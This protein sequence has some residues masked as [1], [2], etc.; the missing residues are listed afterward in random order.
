M[1]F[2]A[3]TLL[4]VALCASTINA[5]TLPRA[6]INTIEDRAAAGDDMSFEAVESLQ[7]RADAPPAGVSVSLTGH[8]EADGKFVVEPA[9]EGQ[10]TQALQKRVSP[11]VAVIAGP[12][13]NVFASV[14]TA[15]IHAAIGGLASMAFWNPVRENFTKNTVKRMWDNN[16]DHAKYPAAICYNKGYGLQ[17]PQGI[18]GLTSAKLTLGALNTDYDCM[19]MEGNNQFYT[20]SEGGYINLAYHYD[21][22]RCTHLRDNGDL[23]CR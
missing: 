6:D 22:N 9:P 16:P 10:D 12:A 3:G 15:A 14:V 2:S 23:H 4:Q 11:A 1:H 7:Q 18:I 13:I 20:H 21:G 8:K 19:Y 5:L 17:R